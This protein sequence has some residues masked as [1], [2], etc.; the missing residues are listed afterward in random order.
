ME[1]LRPLDYSHNSLISQPVVGIT[2]SGYLTI[3]PGLDQ[4]KGYIAVQEGVGSQVDFL[5]AAFA[6]KTFNLVA[7]VGKGGCWVD[8]ALG[9]AAGFKGM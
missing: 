3:S 7:P 8:S 1:L 6:G 2:E 5:L 4:G 9:E